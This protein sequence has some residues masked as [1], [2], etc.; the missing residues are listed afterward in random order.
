MEHLRS[1]VI[2]NVREHMAEIWRQG[3]NKLDGET[4]GEATVLASGDETS[5]ATDTMKP[6]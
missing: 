2:V 5:V 3:V 4:A 1:V 6:T